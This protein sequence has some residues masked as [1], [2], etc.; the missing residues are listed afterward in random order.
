MA[1]PAEEPTPA[2]PKGL[3][4][5]ALERLFDVL[6][7][8]DPP[9]KD[10]LA[11]LKGKVIG[12][13]VESADPESPVTCLYLFPGPWGIR[14][15]DRHEGK[16]NVM[17]SGTWTALARMGLGE[18]GEALFEGD[19]TIV[20]DAGTAQRFRDALKH[21]DPD[22]EGLLARATGDLV[23]HQATVL[24]RGLWHWSRQTARDIPRNLG[25]TLSEEW[26]II[27]PPPALAAFCEDVDRLRDDVDRLEARLNR[28]LK[29][30]SCG[31][32]RR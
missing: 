3:S 32:I 10:D 8:L 5:A 26:R 7:A 25:E 28:L 22:F 24:L 2:S 19:V 14:V 18:K 1:T 29:F 12:L 6:M 4:A 20:G 30:Y 23:A 21:M 9:L 11:P 16:P 17:I 13:R 15:T 31:T 27:A